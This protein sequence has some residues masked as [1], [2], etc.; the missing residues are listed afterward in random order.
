[1]DLFSNLIPLDG[2]G[3]ID[4]FGFKFHTDELLILVILF[5]LYREKVNDTFLYIVLI[6]LLIP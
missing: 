4:I 1:M 3:V 2:N 6:L 5:F